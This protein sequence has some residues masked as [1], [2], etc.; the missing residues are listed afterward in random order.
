MSDKMIREALRSAEVLDRNKKLVP[1]INGMSEGYLQFPAGSTV[2]GCSTDV[3]VSGGS[4]SGML[5]ISFWSSD[6]YS[7]ENE[8]YRFLCSANKVGLLQIVTTGRTNST[9][10]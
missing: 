10:R 1:M 8:R 9:D 6:F 2:C 3:L 5:S 4:G 7:P